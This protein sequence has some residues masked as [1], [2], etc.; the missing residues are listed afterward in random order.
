MPPSLTVRARSIDDVD[1][2]FQLIETSPLSSYDINGITRSEIYTRLKFCLTD[3]GNTLYLYL[4]DKGTNEYN[5]IKQIKPKMNL[6]Y[7]PLNPLLLN[8]GFSFTS[9]LITGRSSAKCFIKNVN[10]QG[11][12]NTLVSSSSSFSTQN[13]IEVK[14]KP[15][16]LIHPIGGNS[17][18]ML[19]TLVV[20][21][22]QVKYKWYKNNVLIDGAD[23][24]NY[25][26]QDYGIYKL[27]ATNLM[28]SV[29]SNEAEIKQIVINIPT[30]ITQP[31]AGTTPAYLTVTADGTMP[32]N[33]QWY[34]DNIPVPS[35]NSSTLYTNETGNYYVVVS[36]SAGSI[37][38]NTVN[39]T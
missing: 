16:I 19:T 39:V 36:N 4:L 20:G 35:G 28:G 34:K 13:E 29:T 9:P 12:N 11:L 2:P 5:L 8:V 14:T 30:I 32:L 17:A 1:D 6:D 15:L 25:Y 24:S 23:S 27:V 22:E 10:V 7:D 26:A 33:Y 21:S 31:T 37:N 18:K 38:S 3:S